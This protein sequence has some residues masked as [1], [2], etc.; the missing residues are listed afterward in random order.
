MGNLFKDNR[1]AAVVEFSLVALPVIFFIFG[2][3][4]TAWIVWAD[5]LLNIAVDTAARCGAVGS[6]TAPCAGT[7]MISAANQVFNALGGA[8][9]TNNT[10]CSNGVGLVGTYDAS[11]GWVVSLTITAQSCYPSVS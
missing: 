7:D 3:M 1:G 5:N 9:F 8:T 6:T 11:I 2:I 10:S 4:Q